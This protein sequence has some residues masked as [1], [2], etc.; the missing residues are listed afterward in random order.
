MKT[1]LSWDDMM[2]LQKKY[3]GPFGNI[4]QDALIGEGVMIDGV[5]YQQIPPAELQRVQELVKTQL[6]K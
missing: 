4:Q 2:D 1:D 5:S 3:K 6:A